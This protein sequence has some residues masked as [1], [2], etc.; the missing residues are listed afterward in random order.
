MER[1]VAKAIDNIKRQELTQNNTVDLDSVKTGGTGVAPDVHG[2]LYKTFT[3]ASLTLSTGTKGRSRTET[4]VRKDGASQLKSQRMEQEL[5]T[6]TLKGDDIE[7][8][9][10]RFHHERV[11]MC[12]DWC[13]HERKRLKSTFEDFLEGIKG[14]VTLF[15]SLATLHDA[16]NMARET[17][18][19]TGFRL[20]ALRSVM[21]K[22]NG[23]DPAR[24]QHHQPQ[25]EDKEC[26]V[27]VL[28]G[29]SKGRGNA[30]KH[31]KVP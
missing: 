31:T 4:L 26:K 6:L 9:N 15:Q 21:Q 14:N 5:W 25:T 7:A 3:N 13:Q 8:Y 24:E 20:S 29:P 12:P 27:Y 23:G 19:N 17:R 2:C 30:G 1:R 10:N 16:I 11:M 22:R 18:L 28:Q